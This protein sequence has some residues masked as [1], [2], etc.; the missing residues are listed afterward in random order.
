VVG[1]PNEVSEEPPPVFGV[2]VGSVAHQLYSALNHVAYALGVDH[3]GADAAHR[4]RRQLD[5]PITDSAAD[6]ETRRVLR[7]VS[8]GARAAF[9]RLQ[10][11][12]RTTESGG[13]TQ[14]PLLLLK[15]LADAD[16][17]RVLAA[18]Y[19]GVDLR[20][21]LRGEG[22]AWNPE[23]AG[24]GE[25]KRTLPEASETRMLGDRVE[26]ARLRFDE[27]NAEATPR[28]DP[29]PEVDIVFESD[30]WAGVS[31]WS[32]GN[33][34]ATTDRC[35]RELADLFPGERWPPASH[36]AEAPYEL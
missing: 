25:F 18:S 30:T 10:P 12:A 29:E 22:F 6:F 27:R 26:L 14:H 34:V 1:C 21:V 8:A 2:L 33:C 31:L 19:G 32:I 15:E 7:H 3:V 9:E 4:K 20:Q 24:G 5:F 13:P 36:D 17:H 23:V 28:V 35:I 16:K 11:Y